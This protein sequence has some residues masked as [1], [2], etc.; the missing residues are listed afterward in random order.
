ME[1]I[2]AYCYG[3]PD[4]THLGPYFIGNEL[5]LS[6]VNQFPVI[7][8]V[9]GEF[10]ASPLAYERRISISVVRD[11]RIP[12]DLAKD[13]VEKGLHDRSSKVRLFAVEAGLIRYIEPLLLEQREL[14]KTEKNH[15]VLQCIAWVLQNM[16]KV[17]F[18]A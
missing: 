10:M 9:W 13:P 7:A 5:L 6:L 14:S 17:P 2:D 4:P 3:S 1:N 18:R 12:F 8:S 15:E 11:S 16:K